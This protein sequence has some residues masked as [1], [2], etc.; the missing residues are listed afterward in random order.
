MNSNLRVTSA[1]MEAF[2]G[3]TLVKKLDSAF[4]LTNVFI[5]KTFIL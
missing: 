5:L 4:E 1:K 3:L 2:S